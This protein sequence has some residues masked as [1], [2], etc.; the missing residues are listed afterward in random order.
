[1]LT[2]KELSALSDEILEGSLPFKQKASVKLHLAMCK[3]CRRYLNY[4]KLTVDM[5]GKNEGHSATGCNSDVSSAEG[6]KIDQIMRRID[7]E[8]LKK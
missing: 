7:K 6:V 1:M 5:I 2:C 3:H 8:V 4:L